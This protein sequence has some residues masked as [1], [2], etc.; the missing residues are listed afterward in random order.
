MQQFPFTGNTVKVELFPP[1]FKPKAVYTVE[2][3]LRMGEII[4]RNMYS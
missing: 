1:G 4:A 2:V 3:L